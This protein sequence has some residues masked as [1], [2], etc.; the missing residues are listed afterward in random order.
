MLER[1]GES[2][3]ITPRNYTFVMTSISI[4]LRSKKVRANCTKKVVATVVA[5]KQEDLNQ[6]PANTGEPQLQTY[7]TVYEYT[8]NGI[9]RRKKAFVGTAKP[10]VS[11]GQKVEIFVN[12]NNADEFYFPLEKD[13]KIAKI[14]AAVGAIIL[15]LAIILQ[16]VL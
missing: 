1:Y 16:K 3:V 2:V 4:F 7:Y 12:P 10:E 6:T 15:I 9:L 11:I 8:V 5:I 14:F 13:T